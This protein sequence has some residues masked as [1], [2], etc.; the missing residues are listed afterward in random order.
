MADGTE[1]AAMKKLRP[2]E[3]REAER[4]KAAVLFMC[5]V[6]VA[7][8]AEDNR[9]ALT[10]GVIHRLVAEGELQDLRVDYAKRLAK[11][12]DLNRA[13]PHGLT[14]FVHASLAK[15]ALT[16]T[17]IAP[18]IA[19][20]SHGQKVSAAEHLN[21]QRLLRDFKS[22]I[23]KQPVEAEGL[24][25]MEKTGKQVMPRNVANCP[26][27]MLLARSLIPQWAYD[28]GLALRRDFDA[29]TVGGLKAFNPMKDTVD[30]GFPSNTITDGQAMAMERLGEAR[31]ALA[32]T[33][34]TADLKGLW[35]L[36]ES[37]A[38]KGERVRDWM[39]IATQARTSDGEK[40]AAR[41]RHIAWLLFALERVAFVYDLCPAGEVNRT[42]TSIQRGSG[43]FRKFMAGVD[44]LA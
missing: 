2:S 32:S 14:N 23:A 15:V 33:S 34:H 37:A 4:W 11:L 25:V 39:G 42:L 28:A 30:G 12:V 38:I 36:L 27:E 6:P 40:M 19:F 16:S 8:I 9:V 24:V 31:A 26:L 41:N 3:R 22:E 20:P 29:A 21:R 1:G 44:A 13:T 10:I 7:R 17:I 18:N 35:A 5:G 43:S